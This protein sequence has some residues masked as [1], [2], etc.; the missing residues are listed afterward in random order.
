MSAKTKELQAANLSLRN[1]H[2]QLAERIDY[3]ASLEPN[4]DGYGSTVI[5]RAAVNK[6][7]RILN[8]IDGHIHSQAGEPFVAPMTDGG[9]ELEW[10]CVFKKELMLVI[11]P[12]G[13]SV[14][15]LLTSCEETDCSGD[16]TG[17]FS[18]DFMVNKLVNSILS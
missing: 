14:R 6:C 18:E 9:L 2:P 8:A 17:D 4:W 3:L 15:F 13:T 10:E 12:E 7:I 5:S 11:P 16:G 1:S